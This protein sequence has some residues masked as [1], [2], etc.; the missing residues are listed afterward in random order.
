[1]VAVRIVLA[2]SS[3]LVQMV[4]YK[5]EINNVRH[6]QV[7]SDQENSVLLIWA[8]MWQCH[9]KKLEIFVLIMEM[10]IILYQF[11]IHYDITVTFQIWSV[12]IPRFR[13]D[14][15]INWTK[16]IGLTFILVSG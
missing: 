4:F 10:E 8:E 3:V 6:V 15:V 11:Q 16:A 12:M 7:D 9:G 13:S 1:M 2:V 14:S 5:K